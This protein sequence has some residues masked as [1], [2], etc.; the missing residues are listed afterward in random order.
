MKTPNPSD[1]EIIQ[2]TLNGG[3]E[4]NKLPDPTTIVPCIDDDTA[5]KIV[6]FAGV[7]LDKA[8]KG[9]ASDIPAV[10]QLIK[11][12]LSQIPQAHL[13]GNP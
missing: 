6:V 3:F 12:F 7:I 2:L 11:D 13:R 10:I 9:S 5:H 1:K 4:Q 8:A